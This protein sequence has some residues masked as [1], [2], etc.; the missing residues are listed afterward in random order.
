MFQLKKIKSSKLY[1]YKAQTPYLNEG[2]KLYI[3]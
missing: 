3:Q 1:W 2:K